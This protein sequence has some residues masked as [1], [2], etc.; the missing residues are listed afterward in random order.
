M[1]V[2]LATADDIE[3]ARERAREAAGKVIPASGNS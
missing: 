3:T 1:G 2:A